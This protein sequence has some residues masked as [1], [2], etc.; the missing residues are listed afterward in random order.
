MRYYHGTSKQF[1]DFDLKFAVRYMDFGMGIYLSQEEWHAELIAKKANKEHA[2]VRCYDLNMSELREKFKVL[3]FKKVS[4]PWVKFVL[5]N[6]S[7]VYLTDYDIVIGATADAK[8][9][10]EINSF[11]K[12]FRSRNPGHKDYRDLISR[13]SADHFPT[14]MC[15]LTQQ[16]VEYVNEHCVAVTDK[17]AE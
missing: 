8:A 7:K 10:A 14:Q 5:N 9:Q 13:L 12:Q 16:A 2:F 11:L 1:K 15:L 4:I 6:R 3:E 17:N